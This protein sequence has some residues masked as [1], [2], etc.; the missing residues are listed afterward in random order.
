MRGKNLQFI[1][2]LLAARQIDY[3]DANPDFAKI[4][5][6]FTPEVVI[7]LHEVLLELWPDSDDYDR[8]A[9]EEREQ[10]TALYTGNYEPASVLRAITRLSLYCDK[11]YLVDPFMRA[12][13]VRDQ[14]N[15]LLH[16][17]EH[18]A[19]TVQYSFLWLTLV[20]W[21]H[22]GIVEFIRPL[23]D[24]VPG[25]WH[26]VIEI[27]RRRF[28]QNPELKRALDDEVKEQMRDVSPLDRGFGEIYILSH[29]KRS[30]A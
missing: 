23:H 27:E 3:S 14:F 22:A 18:R 8:C 16:P 15:P 28:D 19:T 7:R 29:P 24:F 26:E 2:E 17:A 9:S 6:A 20:P 10:V 25:L 12:D 21:I 5:R 1:G 4:K 11:I 30:T 13:R